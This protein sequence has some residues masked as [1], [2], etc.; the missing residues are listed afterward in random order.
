MDCETPPRGVN[1]FEDIFPETGL[2]LTVIKLDARFGFLM[3]AEF[4]QP[5]SPL[6][7]TQFY[8]ILQSVKRIKSPLH[9]LG[10]VDVK[11]GGP[12][13]VPVGPPP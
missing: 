11:G 8:N 3:N 2:L 6:S 12:S 10:R 9:K 13:A 7:S 4:C 5:H 1:P